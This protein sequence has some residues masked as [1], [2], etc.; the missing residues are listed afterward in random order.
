MRTTLRRSASTKRSHEGSSRRRL[1][2]LSV[3]T[4][5]ALAA[6]FVA[7][8]AHV[9]ETRG[10][11][12]LDRAAHRLRRSNRV[13]ALLADGAALGFDSGLQPRDVVHLGS[14]T[15][16]IPAAFVL[17]LLALAC[18][19]R[20]GALVAVAGPG[21]TGALTEYL[22]KPLVNGPEGPRAF[23]SGHTGG[24][25]SIALVVIVLVY[26]RWGWP[27]TVVV[28]PLMAVPVFFV[29]AALLRLDFHYPTDV[30]GGALLAGTVVL[31]LTAGLS[32]YRGPGSR[33]LGTT[34]HSD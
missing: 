33:L 1:L 31:G 28:A 8:A 20:I 34:I 16:V 24:A 4:V 13:D 3:T 19:D 15:V 17:A 10:I 9:W 11:V 12:D 25:T 5:G 26:R 29:G 21:L 22:L 27:P 23:P 30:L 7:L 18:R 6:A 32:L 14:R 2:L